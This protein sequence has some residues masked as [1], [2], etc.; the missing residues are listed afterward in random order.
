MA[1]SLATCTYHEFDPSM[2]IPIRSTVGTPKWFPHTPYGVWEN[3][4]PRR[5]ML[6]MP[7]DEFRRKYRH[8]L[9]KMTFERLVDD[10]LALQAELADSWE[11]PEQLVILC[12]DSLWKPDM[13]CHRT[14]FAEWMSEKGM[15]VRELGRTRHAP[16][17]DADEPQGSLW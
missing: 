13:W 10:A 2:G 11:F 6:N 12:Y 1:L 7:Y 5:W 17:N 16:P 9:H 15:T 4:T 14:M 3:I 8:H